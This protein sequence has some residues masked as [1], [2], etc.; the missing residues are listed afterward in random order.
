[1]KNLDDLLGWIAARLS[2]PSTY[3]GL[4]MLLVVMH[5]NAPAGVTQ[6]ITYIGMGVG[7]ILSIVLKEK[8]AIIPT[9]VTPDRA[10]VMS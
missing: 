7:G 9:A 10:A 8:G 1:M 2:E 6:S 5:L 3:A 4:G